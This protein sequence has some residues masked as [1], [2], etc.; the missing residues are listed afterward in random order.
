[1]NYNFKVLNN[2]YKTINY[3]NKLLV[4]YPKKE[5]VLKNNI[6]KTEYEA[7][8]LIFAYNINSTDRIRDKNLKDLVIKISML[9]FYMRVFF[10]KKIISSHQYEVIGRFIIEIRK[11][12]YGIIRNRNNKD[13]LIKE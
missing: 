11:M 3:I 13:E 9:D 1:M 4:N 7:I 2:T 8:E 10:D 6:E 5:V 12:V